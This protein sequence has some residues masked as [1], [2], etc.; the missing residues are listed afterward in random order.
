MIN[1]NSACDW[2][3]GDATNKQ[4]IDY[5]VDEGSSAHEEIP[6]NDTL[7]IVKVKDDNRFKVKADNREGVASTSQRPQR[8]RVI[9]RRLQDCEMVGDNKVTQDGD[10][11]HFS[12]LAG[13][14]PISYSEASKDK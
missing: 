5:E 14:E 4:L 11:I 13:V 3:S 2:N 10:L 1:E 12:L 8:T 7:A 6:V 9:P